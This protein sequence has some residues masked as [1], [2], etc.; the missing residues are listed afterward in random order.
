MKKRLLAFF[1]ILAILFTLNSA[2]FALALAE[3]SR[4]LQEET[5]PEEETPAE[6]P[7]QAV[8]Y[9]IVLD[10]TTTVTMKTGETHT[11]TATV[12]A[13]GAE[14]DGIPAGMS[15]SWEL[16]HNYNR[17]EFTGATDQLTASIRAINTA[18][19]TENDPVTV[20]VHL[21]NS[22][23]VSVDDTSCNVNVTSDVPLQLEIAD[24]GTNEVDV[25]NTLTLYARILPVG[26][27]EEAGAITWSSA[28]A[29]VATVDASTG[30][31]QGV[32]PGT[33][34]I[35]ARSATGLTDT[36]EVT[37]RGILLPESMTVRANQGQRIELQGFG[38]EVNRQIDQ[39]NVQWST[40]DAS[41][42][43]V[44]NGYLTP[45]LQGTA[46]ITARVSANNRTYEDACTVTVE[47]NT[48]DV[49]R[50]SA[51]VGDPLSFS[52][53]E[54]RIEAE[55]RDV[56]GRSLSYVSGLRVD[57]RQ[58]TLYYRYQ[59]ESDTGAGV[60]TGEN[61][62]PNPGASQMDLSDITFVPKSDFSGT[63]VISYTG[64]ADA[65]SFFQGTIEVDVEEAEDVAYSTAADR[66]LQFNADDFN[67]ICR[68]RTGRDL[69]YV[70]FS[71]PDAADGTLYQGY[72]SAANPGRVVETSTQYRRSGSPSLSDVYFVPASG[73]SG[74]VIVT[75]T[76][77]D[78]N[79]NTYRGRVTIQIS[80]A[81]GS[82][83]INYSI[84]QG[85]RVTLDADDF[86]DLSRS[87]TGSA[88]DYVQ[89]QLPDSDE[90]TLYYNYTSGG[91]YDS[92]VT[93][94]R[95]YYRNSSPY[96]RRVTFAADEDF[97]GTAEFGF[98]AW[99][100]RGDRFTG[101]VEISVGR[102]GDGDIRY[103]C[104]SDGQ[105]DFDDND[106]NDLCRDLTGESLS[107][108]RFDLPSSSE[109]RLYYDYDDG[110]YG[111]QVTESRSYYRNSSPYLDRVSFVP[112]RDFSGTSVI[113]FT[114]WSTGGERFNGT[115]E[116]E[117]GEDLGDDAI[118][119]RVRSGQSVT[120]DE[121]DFDDLCQDATGERLRYVRFELPSASRGTLYYD[122]DDGDYDSKVT[123]SRSYYRSQSPYLNRVTFVP[124]NGFSGAVSIDFTGRSTDNE[125]F[126]GTVEIVV[127]EPAAATVITY[128][129][130]YRPVTL[131]AQD[132]VS[133]CAARGAGE[134]S[135]VRFTQ[136]GGSG[137]RLYYGYAGTNDTG[138]EARTGTSYYPDGSPSLSDLT[139]VPRAGYTG[140]TTLT[141]TGWDTQGNSYQGQV[142]ITCRASSYS[143]YFTDMTNAA[144]A[145]SAVDYLYEAG[146]VQGGGDGRFRPSEAITRADFVL[147]LY[148]AFDLGSMGGQ[149]SGFQD[150]PANSYYA[151]AVRTTQ[152]L[153]I[154]TGAD[155]GGFHPTDPVTR[156]DAAVLL[157]RTMQRTG[158]S[159]GAG[160]TNLLSGYSDGWSVAS[161]AQSAMAI[162]IEYGIVSGTGDGSLNPRGTTSRAEMAV[163]LS[164]AMTL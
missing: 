63:A 47:A 1:L 103:T 133:A 99:S 106:F 96:L 91:D 124:E 137:G 44:S 88:L 82:G 108:V 114:G 45:M 27:E 73:A 142:Q 8:A 70:T 3:P 36:C 79:G 148:R 19:T 71:L 143:Q 4:L 52:S 155:D 46:T 93:E 149:G 62:Y 89:F 59:S 109:G 68:L 39:A 113:E 115:V 94:S 58:G 125:T 118:T 102:A 150:V 145:V 64:Y 31:V 90:G 127:E 131:R 32:A 86:N 12:Y 111:S 65:T 164:R 60:G 77:Y 35:T 147:M 135:Y 18:E 119:Y 57:T 136:I 134:L 117:V 26:R 146:V 105:A 78:V 122:Y 17:V 51:G 29:A 151:Q 104:R 13:D 48:A 140:T 61:Y 15:V 139:F 42:V 84:S 14:V 85:G 81:S 97:T 28:N 154:A 25:E 130:D 100:T 92:R 38:Q 55:C 20:T 159:L 49:I 163:M 16:E 141:Y 128:T 98:T 107:Y 34:T 152:A 50:A 5:S 158:W 40:S 156:Q 7:S 11:F 21:R 129:T 132:F 41:V 80:A 110:D 53:I 6:E 24:S 76:G 157:Q 121:A 30:A 138:S 22:S 120:F 101:T 153:G 56:L 160:N 116:I 144:W 10:A 112:R 23:G 9:T 74:R 72:L 37:V 162:M 87:L 126:H 83:D 54:S 33:T 75:Y 95:S 123:E 43:T 67:R 69:S 161:Y 2:A 66:V